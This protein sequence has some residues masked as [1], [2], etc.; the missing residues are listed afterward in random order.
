MRQEVVSDE[1]AEEDKVVDEAFEVHL[2]L[3]QGGREP[4]IAEFERERVS[5]DRNVQ[6]LEALGTRSLFLLHL[7]EGGRGAL[8]GAARG[9]EV[10]CLSEQG[11]VRLVGGEGEH[12]EVSV[13]AVDHVP[14]VRRVPGL[15]L[16]AADVLHDL[17]LPLSRHLSARKD[18]ARTRPVEVLFHFGTDEVV[19]E[20]CEARHELRP[21]GDAVGVEGLGRDIVTP[22][23][24]LTDRR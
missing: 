6:Q 13:V 12:D 18:D 9:A 2:P 15:A 16:F 20:V 7:G 11:E 3:V 17:V 21:R 14:Q 1:V 22:L 10:H 5:E 8:L 23:F 19:Q 4:G 24:R